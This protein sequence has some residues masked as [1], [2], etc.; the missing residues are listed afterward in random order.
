MNDYESIDQ[1]K[2]DD[3]V[4]KCDK[5]GGKEFKWDSDSL[6]YWCTRCNKTYWRS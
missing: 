5:C 6:H 2:H 1:D 4:M 3:F